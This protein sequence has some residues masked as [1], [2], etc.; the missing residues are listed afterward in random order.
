MSH[1]SKIVSL[2]AIVL[3]AAAGIALAVQEGMVPKSQQL[4]PLICGVNAPCP[5]LVPWKGGGGGGIGIKQF[6]CVNTQS[7][8]VLKIVLGIKNI[9]TAK[10]TVAVKTLA[11]VDG[12]VW[13]NPNN[14]N[15][16]A[17]EMWPNQWQEFSMNGPAPGPGT[18]TLEV[19]VDSENAQAELK[20]NNNVATARTTCP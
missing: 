16:T 7:G 13:N 15:T 20:E 14:P 8:K 2:A 19:K 11:K 10:T 17:A 6:S 1:V 4:K 18:H 5:D 3:L 9:G 12:A